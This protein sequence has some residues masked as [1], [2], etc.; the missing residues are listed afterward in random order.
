[1]ATILSVFGTRPEVVKLAPV[2][3][4]LEN[5][6]QLRTVN[7]CSS[8]H[9]ELAD[10][11]ARQLGVRID[12]DLRVMAPEQTPSQVCARVLAGLDP[13]L[14]REQPDLVLVQGDTTTALAAALA[15]FHRGFPV[16][17][18]EAGLRSGDPGQPFPEEMNR[19]LVTQLAQLH[20]APTQHNVELLRREG[21]PAD[22]IAL[23]GNP[24][25]DAL[26][27]SLRQ[28]HRSPTLER[29][30]ARLEGRQLIVLTTHRRE[31]HGPRMAGYLR[32]LRR[33]V[34]R[35][36]QL[37]LVFPVHPNPAV[38]RAAER[39]LSG[40]ERVHPID[41]LPYP[42][43]I[44]LLSRA[45][46]I[47]SDSGG[48]QEEAPTLGRPLLVLRDNTERPEAVRD[49]VA[50]LVGRSP[51]RLDAMLEAALADPGWAKRL[52]YAPNPFG[53]GKSG[54]RIAQAIA[55]FLEFRKA[56]S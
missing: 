49:G 23:T 22:R 21:V 30:F 56:V 37:A 18:V 48:V 27:E 29:L 35:H 3:R 42:E 38:R 5:H 12:H 51:E 28:R 53:D 54:E 33:F 2:V 32:T 46:L 44:Q 9:A 6:D 16:G 19:R 34:A 41:P 17:H 20:F 8:Q 36:P 39:E 1:M 7:V 40:A 31:N 45:W 4:A 47:V 52:R 15:A 43:F 24:V 26:E 55:R 50:R 14:A 11:F 25:V 10:R 13:L